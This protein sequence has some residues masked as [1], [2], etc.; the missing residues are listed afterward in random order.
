MSR[1]EKF[2]RLPQHAALKDATTVESGLRTYA[3]QKGGSAAEKASSKDSRL[4][5]LSLEARWG[6]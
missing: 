3:P 6:L 4:E 5:K 1:I 2:L